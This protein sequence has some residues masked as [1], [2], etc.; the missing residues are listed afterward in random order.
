M[1]TTEKP[2]QNIIFF[3]LLLLCVCV[4]SEESRIFTSVAIKRSNNSQYTHTITYSTY[5]LKLTESNNTKKEKKRRFF[6]WSAL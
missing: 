6:I 2:R 1:K 5:E 4:W 3:S